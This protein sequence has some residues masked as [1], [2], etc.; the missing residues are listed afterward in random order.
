VITIGDDA[1]DSV[2]RTIDLAG[3]DVEVL[4][5]DGD[6]GLLVAVGVDDPAEDAAED[7]SNP[8]ARLVVQIADVLTGEARQ[9][10]DLAGAAL[11]P[12]DLP[13]NGL[14]EDLP[15]DGPPRTSRP[16][17]SPRASRPMRNSARSSTLR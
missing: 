15:A 3:S 13:A 14:P 4:D 1:A 16:M 17:A 9:V 12:E 7:G 8:P 10:I 2:A 5:F 6:Q 11:I